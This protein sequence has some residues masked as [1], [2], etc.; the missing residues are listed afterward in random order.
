MLHRRGALTRLVAGLALALGLAAAITPLAGTRVLAQTEDN[1]LASITIYTA[2]CP[3]GYAGDNLFGDCYGTPGTDIAYLLTGPA[4]PDTVTNTTGSDGFTAFEGI[5]EAGT[6]DLQV[7]VPGD[8]A[9]FVIFCSDEFGEP[10]AAADS[11]EI[12]LVEL[13]LTLDD[14]V[15][16]DFYIIPENLSGQTPTVQPTQA[17]QA[18]S[19]SVTLPN[20][21]TG[22][23]GGTGSPVWPLAGALALLVIAGASLAVGR[24]RY[25]SAPTRVRR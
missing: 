12:G 9:D 4:F 24:A 6:Y 22:P 17:P 1:G 10:F 25:A 18:T 8:A 11:T 14:D 3:V 15:K 13:D 19:T 23:T 5:D 16:C 21:G 2:I 7:D 20:T